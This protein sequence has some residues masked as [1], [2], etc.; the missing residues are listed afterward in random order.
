MKQITVILIFLSVSIISFAQTAGDALRY[1]YWQYGGS[2]RYM[3][4]AGST[5]A[6][7]GD[8][9]SIISNPA[10]IA[11]FRRSEFAL[12]PGISIS[13]TESNF[14]GSTFSEKNTKVNISHASIIFAQSKPGNWKTINFGLGYNKL[15]DFNQTFNYTGKTQGSIVNHFL[16]M[17]QGSDPSQLSDLDT[18]LA[19]DTDL[20][21]LPDGSVPTFYE[22]DFSSEDQVTKFQNVVNSGSMGEMN[23]SAGGNFDHKLYLGASIGIPFVNYTSTKAYEETDE[24]DSIANFNSME[25]REN[26]NTTGIGVNINIGAIYRVNQAVRLGASLH[27]PTWLSLTDSYSNSVSSNLTLSGATSEL[28]SES[29]VFNYEYRQSTPMRLK[30]HMGFIIK[31]MGFVSAEVEYMNYGK[32]K[33]NFNNVSGSG[34]LVLESQLNEEIKGIFQSTVNLKVGTEFVIKKQYRVRAGY[35]LFG[36]PYVNNT[37]LFNSNQFSIGAGYRKENFF[38]DLAYVHRTGSEFYQAYAQESSSP[39]LENDLSSDNILLTIGLKF[40]K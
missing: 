17:A 35:A 26:L 9:S 27:S 34:D 38:I 24:D 6:L 36:N 12:T 18:G 4:T 15:A 19:Y 8:Y 22:N 29:E 11:S 1:S 21:Y 33:Y 32:N 30:G 28:E 16:N 2:A 40:G 13:G 5:G 25:F 31:K 37:E 7:G 20:I 23:L 39:M 10:S 3:A 14:D